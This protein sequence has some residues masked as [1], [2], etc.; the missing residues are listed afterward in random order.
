MPVSM[1]TPATPRTQ[2]EAVKNAWVS[3]M[4][5][6]EVVPTISAHAKLRKACGIDS[7]VGGREAFDLI[8][9]LTQ[10]SGTPHRIKE[11]VKKISFTWDRQ[12]QDEAVPAA[13]R[14]A[15]VVISGAGPVGLRAAVEAAMMG[16]DVAVLEKREVFSRV[17]IL[18]LWKQTADD[19]VS[20]GARAFYPKFSNMADV[21]HL[22]TREIQLV[23]LKNALLLGVRFL[24]G[25][26][27]VALQAPPPPAAGQPAPSSLWSAWVKAK[28][29]AEL[30][31]EEEEDYYK[32]EEAAVGT[33]AEA[34]ALEEAEREDAE[35]ATPRGV[36]GGVAAAAAAF[37]ARASAAEAA[38]VLEKGPRK[39]G[40]NGGKIMAAMKAFTEKPEEAPA[41]L[42]GRTA[43]KR[44][45]A[46]SAAAAMFG[47]TVGGSDGEAE[48]PPVDLG[49]GSLEFK[50]DK[51]ADY[52]K[53]PG[54]GRLNYMQTSEL[55]T[56][57]TLLDGASAPEGSTS[58]L[59]FEVLLLAE[60][61]WS[62]SCKRLGVTKAIDRF[63]LAIGLVI[64]MLID[65]DDAVSKKKESYC[66][67]SLGPVVSGLA[68]AGILVE[69]VEYLRGETHYIAVTVKK[70]SLL[71]HRVLRK[72]RSALDGAPLLSRENVDDEALLKLA[73]TVATVIGLPETTAFAHP[74]PAKLFDF[75]T[76][77]ARRQRRRPPGPC[78]P[79]P[80]ADTADCPRPAVSRLT[81]RASRRIRPHP[82]PR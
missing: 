29:D 54:Q 4:E 64:N 58:Q 35:A 75:S 19:L 26:E 34:A 20:F 14:G 66:Q 40:Q 32:A 5:A 82:A 9:R 52:L 61:E 44:G 59:P 65:P 50:P 6:A 39:K 10:A 57:F 27:L 70:V 80:A 78:R 68:D 17:N 28:T 51:T 33:A 18:T 37:A 49:I 25:S 24:Y 45:K 55:D 79:A 30:G 16:M 12:R 22:G 11:L 31:I 56:S 63:S 38:P 73:R 1:T 42:N 43:G 23:L 67:T 71:N 48:A 7:K 76:R 74:H 62:Q 2:G 46:I 47:G 8:N 69:N 60:G 77:G 41:P 72:D 13:C 15:R 81:H 3:F 36:A 53:G 21:L